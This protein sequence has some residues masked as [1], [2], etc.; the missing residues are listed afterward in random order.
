MRTSVG[1]GSMMKDLDFLQEGELH[2]CIAIQHYERLQ[3][4]AESQEL[5]R[6]RPLRH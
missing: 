1:V 2:A 5:R 4:N 3:L 6:H